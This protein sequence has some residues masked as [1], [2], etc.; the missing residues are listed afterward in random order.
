MASRNDHGNKPHKGYC[1]AWKQRT[2][3]ATTWRQCPE[4]RTM[5]VGYGYWQQSMLE[6]R[7]VRQSRRGR[8]VCQVP[9]GAGPILC[10]CASTFPWRILSSKGPMT[11]RY[12]RDGFK[13]MGSGGS[14]LP[15]M[16]VVDRTINWNPCHDSPYNLYNPNFIFCCP[17]IKT[18]DTPI[19]SRR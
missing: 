17:P 11:G 1:A 16:D 8:T 9:R 12:T 14:P 10:L 15:Q 7:N 6:S 5:S 18:Y 19:N 4:L 2:Q 13:F 3:C